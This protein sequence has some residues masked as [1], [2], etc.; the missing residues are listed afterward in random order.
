MNEYNI[1]EEVWKDVEGYEGSYS[2]SSFGRIKSLERTIARKD[3][4]TRI[5]C[6]RFL[7]PGKNPD[8]YLI[9][10]LRKNN[11]SKSVTVHSLVANGF[12]KRHTE[13]LQIN[14][15]DGVKTNN[16]LDN[17]EFVTRSENM[18][19]ASM[20]GLR[21]VKLTPT[22]AFEIKE[23]YEKTDLKQK[24]IGIIYGVSKQN[25]S[26]ICRNTIWK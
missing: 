7:K 6:E 5:Q 13:C 18:K 11:K 25:V 23:L 15:I 8:G 17:L 16:R 14:H 12:L 9:V 2:V 20:N 26:E 19:H 3:G 22:E 24:E 4:Y 21:M 1:Q 10:V